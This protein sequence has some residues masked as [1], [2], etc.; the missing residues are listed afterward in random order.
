MP[1]Q[2]PQ[3]QQGFQ[4]QRPPSFGQGA[5]YTDHF[6]EFGSPAVT[7]GNAGG[8]LGGTGMQQIL[9]GQHQE[10]ALREQEM[11]QAQTMQMHNMNSSALHQPPLQAHQERQNLQVTL[12]C[13]LSPTFKLSLT[14]S[15]LSSLCSSR[16]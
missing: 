1:L 10:Q 2:Q 14:C 15:L 12:A 9:Q 8:Q 7:G 3:T 5:S 6:R 16:L 13:F 11:R 4:I